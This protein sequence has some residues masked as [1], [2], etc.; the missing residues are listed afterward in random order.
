MFFIA[1]NGMKMSYIKDQFGIAK[2]TYYYYF[3]LIAKYQILEQLYRELIV[4]NTTLGKND[5]V[6]TDTF[7][8]KSM[9]GSQ[10][11]GRNPTDRGRK[12]LKVSLICDH[13]LVT[14]A[15]HVGDANIHDAQILPET[16]DVSMTDLTGLN[17]LADSGSAGRR[18][19]DQIE[20]KHK[21]H[22][23]SKP[24]R[25]RSPS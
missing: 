21:I 7:T 25:T 8:V 17:C 14:H 12:G 4:E 24:K 22:L 5:F 3:N 19:I 20:H 2:S 10:G 6:I 23:I 13:N 16:I 11:L 1:D 15:V 18:S 9:D